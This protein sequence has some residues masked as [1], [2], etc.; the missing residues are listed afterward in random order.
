[1]GGIFKKSILLLFLSISIIAFQNCSTENFTTQ[2]N[3]Q[4]YEGLNPNPGTGED[5]EIGEPIDEEGP[6]DG[7]EGP[8]GSQQEPDYEQIV[9]KC[10]KMKNN[11]RHFLKINFAYTMTG[12]AVIVFYPKNTNDNVLA[13]NWDTT[14][15]I[16]LT[17]ANLKN[18][19]RLRRAVQNQYFSV[20]GKLH[21]KIK[22][23]NG[24]K[25]NETF[26]C[27]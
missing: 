13:F 21:L 17:P 15:R 10:I 1:M 25:A 19:Y 3:G 9:Y 4:P 14:T 8:G 5:I 11:S 26:I 12:K 27:N 16:H 6:A 23:A 18:G 24:D 2:G 20:N 7:N 22:D